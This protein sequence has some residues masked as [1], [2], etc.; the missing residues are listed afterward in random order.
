MNISNQQE[1]SSFEPFPRWLRIT[2]ILITLCVIG[3]IVSCIGA[4]KERKHEQ[5]ANEQWQ[6]L[7]EK[8]YTYQTLVTTYRDCRESTKKMVQE[9]L[10]ITSDYAK[11]VGL[12]DESVW[13]VRDIKLT[14]DAIKDAYFL[15]ERKVH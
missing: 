6:N 8:S 11:S 7:K 14:S 10:I 5:F 3:I 4:W 9:C 2:N 12:Q 13:V 15:V 1:E